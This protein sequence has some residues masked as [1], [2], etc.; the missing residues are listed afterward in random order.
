[1]YATPL[2]ESPCSH[3]GQL[4][5]DVA[6]AFAQR[7]QFPTWLAC[8]NAPLSCQLAG[9][10]VKELSQ[11]SIDFVRC[12]LHHP[13]RR[14]EIVRDEVGARFLHGGKREIDEVDVVL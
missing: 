7:R 1:M 13:M 11:R 12:L 6:N 8:S 3:H 10:C 2:D 4:D 9:K 14:V 5:I